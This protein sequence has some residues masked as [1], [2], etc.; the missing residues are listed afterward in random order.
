MNI[1]IHCASLKESVLGVGFAMLINSILGTLYYN[2]VIAWALFYFILSF[3]S[4]LLWSECDH[5]WNTPRCIM[6]GS[7]STSSASNGIPLNRTEISDSNSDSDMYRDNNTVK[8]VATEE[9]F[10]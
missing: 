4:Q 9:F 1:L 10:L 6:P 2:V 5:W 3:R 8:V 7:N